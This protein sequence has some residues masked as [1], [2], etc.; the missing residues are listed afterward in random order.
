MSIVPSKLIPLQYKDQ[1][2]IPTNWDE[3][4]YHECP[5]QQKMWREAITKELDK[6]KT[7][8]VYKIIKRK[9]IPHGRKCVKH[10][11]VFDI[12][13]NGLFRARLV[14]CGYSQKPGIN[15]TDTYSPVVNDAVFRECSL[16]SNYC[17]N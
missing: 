5:F 11:W 4:W 2:Y 3:A 10:K 15:F 12:K 8:Q 14:A 16:S 13:R 1:F 17:F 9:E 7:Y 6:M